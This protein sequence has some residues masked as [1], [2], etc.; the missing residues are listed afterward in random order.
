MLCFLCFLCFFERAAAGVGLDGEALASAGTLVATSPV[1]NNI[2]INFFIGR[3]S[4]CGH[5]F[6]IALESEGRRRTRHCAA[7]RC[8]RQLKYDQIA[9][10]GVRNFHC[11]ASKN[12]RWLFAAD[13]SFRLLHGRFARRARASTA[14]L[15][16]QIQ[17]RQHDQGQN[18]R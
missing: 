17:R 8:R 2:A 18:R 11:S 16:H 1:S 4:S 13:Q 10:T 5:S 6:E 3:L 15:K 14:P 12:R 7:P 9:R